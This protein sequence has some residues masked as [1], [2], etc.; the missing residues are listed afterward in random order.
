MDTFIFISFFYLL[1][2]SVLG[3][4]FLLNSL[5]FSKMSN[6]FIIPDHYIGFYGITFLTFISLSTNIFFAH[7]YLHNS[8]VH[9]FGFLFSCYYFYK[10]KNSN[11]L[12][13]IFLISLILLSALFISK[14]NEDFPYY[15]L[16]YTNY[17]TENKL[18]FGSGHLDLGYNLLSSIFNFNSTFRLPFIDIYSFHFIYIYFLIFFNYFLFC[19]IFKFKNQPFIFVL[20]IISALYFNL[21]F[22]RIAEFGTDKPGQ[23]LIVLITIKLFSF[24]LKKKENISLLILSILPLLA[25]VFSLKAYFAP[26]ILILL[27]IIFYQKKVFLF[28]YDIV[29][30]RS[31]IFSLVLIALVCT[32]YFF[33]TGC[34]IAPIS[35][36][37]VGDS[38]SWAQSIDSMTSLSRWLEQWAKAGAG[39]N[40]RVD[41]P[42][43]YV[44]NLNWLSN[45]FDKYFLVK[46]VDQIGIF[47]S[48]L[49]FVFYCLFD[50]TKRSKLF[51]N[52]KNYF[53]YLPILIIFL[54][55]FLKHPTLRYGGYSIVFLSLSIPISIF[56]SKYS[57]K[58]N[59]NRNLIILFTIVSI[60]FN[61]KNLIRIK[62]EFN[63]E[64]T[65]KYSNFPY[66]AVLNADYEQTKYD[67]GLIIYQPKNI[68]NQSNYCWK[69]PSPC[70][71]SF[72][73]KLTIELKNG[74][75][76]ISP[77][78]LY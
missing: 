38:L 61:T 54:I 77:A 9:V 12:K 37:C 33:A 4:G 57:F 41:D 67:S 19:E 27:P 17:L 43:E 35:I 8:V 1:L 28:I 15:H 55:W 18:I 34:L 72:G 44:K 51:F 50:F 22:N 31:F 6:N 29:I 76:F 40:F 3:Y 47:V 69:I 74:Y 68:K 73:L 36:L 30:T 70:T 20:Y 75:Y 63:R 58:K 53:F 21:S 46:V 64:D 14:T 39:P 2:L 32:H 59:L 13:Y 56:F 60:I 7:D 24:F 78:K 5:L 11:F 52:I 62:N 10:N 65:Y 23:L 45:W 42:L 48:C 25:Y 71:M 49:I 66:Y 16:T 26:Y